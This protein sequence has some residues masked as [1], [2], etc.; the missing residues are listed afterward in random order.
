[1]RMFT[2]NLWKNAHIDQQPGNAGGSRTI[3]P[4]ETRAT[5]FRGSKP[6]DAIWATTDVQI[7]GACVLPAGYGVGYHRLFVIDLATDS[8]LGQFPKKIV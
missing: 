2:K 1:M 8:V 6:I 5:F 3:H 4:K 7:M